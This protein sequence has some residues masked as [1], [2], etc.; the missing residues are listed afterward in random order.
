MS[1]LK[2]ALTAYVDANTPAGTKPWAGVS[3]PIWRR[4]RTWVALAAAAVLVLGVGLLV[5]EVSG[6]SELTVASADGGSSSAYPSQRARDWVTYA[7][8]VVVVTPVAEDGLGPHEF[9]DGEGWIDRR[10]TLRVDEVLWSRA[11]PARPL[12]GML[13]VDMWGWLYDGD[14]SNRGRW[15]GEGWSRVELGHS[16][17]MA[18]IWEDARCSPGDE[19]QPGEW[20]DLGEAGTVA[21]DNGAVGEGEFEGTFRTAEEAAEAAD[22]RDP[23]YTFAQ[24]MTGLDAAAVR[25][26][27]EGTE[28]GERRQYTEPAP[29][30]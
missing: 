27:L 9:E 21:Y 6:P 30:D 26:V 8:H 28:P 1:D 5:R 16:Y 25:E 13:A 24:R 12:S 11:D 2:Q 29:C 14:P 23:N 20:A 18:V 4:P 22:P 15:V 17:I 3:P 10:V 19:S 7:D